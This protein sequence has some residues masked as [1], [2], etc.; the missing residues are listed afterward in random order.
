MLFFFNCAAR[1][2]ELL[3]YLCIL[4][5]PTFL[6]NNHFSLSVLL[7]T[8]RPIRLRAEIR[9]IREPAK[10]TQ[11]NPTLKATCF[12]AGQEIPSVLWSSKVP[13]R[14]QKCPS[15]VLLVSHFNPDYAFSSYLRYILIQGV[16]LL[17]KPGSSLIILPLMR[18]LQLQLGA[19]Q[20]HAFHFSHNER[21]R[22]Q[23]S[24]QY[25]HSW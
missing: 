4:T 25:P 5:Y 14:F 21:T 2:S 20:T 16:P 6:P 18:I 3:Q 13:N 1:S 22:V 7:L 17:T 23:I 12:S 15:L 19:L 8:V 11:Q 9:N 24:L 10:S